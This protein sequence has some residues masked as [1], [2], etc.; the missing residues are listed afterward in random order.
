[1][2]KSAID[3]DRADASARLSG[4]TLRLVLICAFAYFL[5][6]LVHSD[7]GPLAPGIARSL[8]LSRAELGPVFSANLVGQCIGLIVVPLLL[9]RVNHR[10][11]VVAMIIGFGLAHTLT[12][13]ATGRDSLIVMRVITGFFLGGA[14]PSGL[15][16]VASQ[17]PLARRGMAISILFTGYGLGAIVAGLIASLFTGDDAWRQAMGLIGMSSLGAAAIAW[18]WL[19][20]EHPTERT[21]QAAAEPSALAIF[22]PRYL[23]GTLMLWL[24]FIAMLT[25]NYCLYSWLPTLLVDVGRDARFAALSVS[26]F[27]TGGIVATL[28]V[29]PL[30]DRFGTQR[31]LVL[32]L[33]VAAITLF[34][35]GQNLATAT[36]GTLLT[37]LSVAGFCSL[38]AYTGVNVVLADFYPE[39]LRA[40]GVG[41]TKSVS[42]IGTVVAPILIGLGLSAGVPETVIMSLFVIPAGVTLLAVLIIGAAMRARAA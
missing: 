39:A 32:F 14:L 5:D 4:P 36:P 19:P 26:F 37:L 9:R 25:I 10:T 29:G 27:A 18:R 2:N 24:I 33:I 3:M 20:R 1:M 11:I 34:L 15:A 21:G 42:R 6:G 23:V 41:W 31:V 12:G 13:L 35:V 8:S 40:V 22:G 28:G 7:M 16:M 30:I 38:G 17:T